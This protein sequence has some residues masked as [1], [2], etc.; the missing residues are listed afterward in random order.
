MKRFKT[1]FYGVYLLFFSFCAFLAF[2]Y[3]ELVLD[4]DW[5]PINTWTGLIRFVLKMGGIGLILFLLEIIIENIHL[6]TK[7]R[8][9]KKL[10]KEVL[11]IKASLYD[12]SQKHVPTPTLE[13]ES[14]LTQP[15][16]SF[17]TG[18]QEEEHDEPIA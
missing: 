16:N 1:F 18:E 13:E 9:I 8:K 7:N 14:T 10:E 6:F 17:P 3:E 15:E 12:Q 4:W 5:D 2:F 11:E